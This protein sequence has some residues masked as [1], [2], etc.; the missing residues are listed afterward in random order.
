MGSIQLQAFFLSTNLLSVEG[1]RKLSAKREIHY[2]STI[3]GTYLPDVFPCTQPTYV[4]RPA[5]SRLLSNLLQQENE[6]SKQLSQLL[7]PLNAS[8]ASF[9]AY[10]A[11]SPSGFH[12]I[13]S[14]VVVGGTSTM[15]TTSTALVSTSSTTA[16]EF[17][18]SQWCPAVS[19]VELSF[20]LHAFMPGRIRGAYQFYLT[21]STS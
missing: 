10:A 19:I 17:Q 20:R 2:V 14:V 18:T 12:V 7:E 6:Y 3:Y 21:I 13:M 1:I 5:D 15:K 11:A 9:T 8:L 16:T 4:H